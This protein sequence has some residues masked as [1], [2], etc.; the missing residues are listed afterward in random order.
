MS[1]RPNSI[2][3]VCYL[4][5]IRSPIAEGLMKKRFGRSLYVQSAGL[6]SGELDDL[7]V[8]VMAEKGIDMSDHKSRI[9]SDLGDTN[10]DMVIA[11]TKNAAEAAKAMF[12][13]TDTKVET[14]LVPANATFRVK[15]I[16][17]HEIIAHTAGRMRKNRIRVLA[18]D[19]VTVEMTPYDLTKG[20][21]TYRFK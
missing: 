3:F 21:I 8:A 17:D 20:R 9:L 7:M 5:S 4:N 1:A 12:E 2:L 16:N 19:K 15:L 18:G 10:Y 11:F 14:W 13:G 6:A